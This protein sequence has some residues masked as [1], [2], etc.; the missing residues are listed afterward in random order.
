[1]M[2]CS[3]IENGSVKFSYFSLVLYIS[4]GYVFNMV[5]LHINI[6]IFFNYLE[7]NVEINFSL[8]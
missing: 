8:F 5:H 4:L 3:L 7:F 6:Q 1:M 2:N